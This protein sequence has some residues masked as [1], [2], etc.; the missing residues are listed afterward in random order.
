MVKERFGDGR[1][2]IWV[3]VAYGVVLQM[4]GACAL[5]DA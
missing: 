2:W 5:R 3:E 4:A 1:R